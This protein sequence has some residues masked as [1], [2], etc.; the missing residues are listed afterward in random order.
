[1]LTLSS[2]LECN[3]SIICGSLPEVRPIFMLCFGK[4]TSSLNSKSYE[5]YNAQSQRPGD[6]YNSRTTG[7]ERS[8]R[9]RQAASADSLHAFNQWAGANNSVAHSKQ[10]VALEELS[11]DKRTKAVVSQRA[12]RESGTSDG[13][14]SHGS[15][16]MWINGGENVANKKNHPRSVL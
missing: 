16:D 15:E 6:P 11:G 5:A 12:Q 7:N 1:V 10:S 3:L 4:P 14:E 8:E 2:N 13:H 9:S